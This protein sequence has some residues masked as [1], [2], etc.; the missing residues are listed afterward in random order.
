VPCKDCK[1]CCKSTLICIVSVLLI[2]TVVFVYRSLTIGP[3]YHDVVLES[4]PLWAVEAEKKRRE[5][6]AS[7]GDFVTSSTPRYFATNM[8]TNVLFPFFNFVQGFQ[9]TGL[10]NSIW[11]NIRKLFGCLPPKWKPPVKGETMD[12]VSYD[13][14]AR[15][16]FSNPVDAPFFK[17]YFTGNRIPS[18]EDNDNHRAGL[19]LI[20]GT[21]K[22]ARATGIEPMDLYAPVEPRFAFD[23][24]ALQKSAWD[25]F[26]YMGP[27][28]IEYASNGIYGVAVVEQ[29]MEKYNSSGEVLGVLMTDSVFSA[30]LKRDKATN[31]FHVDLDFM[32]EY[33][34]IEGY[35]PLGGRAS[36]VEDGQKLRTVMLEYNG[37][38]YTNFDVPEVSTAYMQ[39]KRSGWRMAEGAIIASL[40]SMTNL[41]MHVKDL[42]LELAAGFQATT[43]D[44]FASEPTHPV[45]LLMDPYI[46]RSAQATNDNFKLLF[47]YHAAE[48]SLA[49]LS[50]AEQ[51]RLI[52]DAVRDK[53]LNL[54]TFDMETYGHDRN[55]DPLAST[56]AA[57]TNSSKW[58][59]RWH[60]RAL[61]VQR[62]YDKLISCWLQAHYGKDDEV[63]KKIASDGLLQAWYGA[64]IDHLPALKSATKENPEWAAPGKLTLRTLKNVLRT[65]FVWLSWIHEDVGHSAASYVYNPIH[66]PMNVPTDGVGVPALSWTFNALAYRGFVFLHRS[67]L[68]DEP[69][70]FWFEGKDATR[71]CF[72]DFQESLAH[73][74]RSDPA[75]SECD[76]TGFYSCVNRVETAVSS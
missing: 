69:P 64:I 61:T 36:F 20:D 14:Y 38:K 30:H 65:L 75:F 17:D 72:T 76:K 26:R 29:L 55:I 15:T 22:T 1:G 73:L 34:S 57:I 60:Y 8:G 43:V 21:M 28:D 2:G 52:G 71:Q 27:L 18:W 25:G 35:A 49:P 67:V 13:E 47:E 66:T 31:L 74:G 3:A 51:L 40:L 37:T 54:A 19:A 53:P 4:R 62:L 39:S 23:N 46:S 59:W 56:G 42:H 11:W 41:V 48:F 24:E 63:E 32:K 44:A 10:F 16:H 12:V 6:A 5:Y 45:R 50:T 33:K 7:S 68:M 58:G 70:A 9:Q